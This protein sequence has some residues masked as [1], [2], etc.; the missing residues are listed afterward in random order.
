MFKRTDA[1]SNWLI[2]DSSRGPYNPD[3]N[4]LFPNLSA[5]EDT[6]ENYDLLSNG[7]KL[8]DA[9]GLANNGT[10]IY[11]AFAENPFNSSRAR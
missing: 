2:I 6:S 10:I 11:A 3:Q 5:A 8:R 1:T 4:R 9:S 7:F